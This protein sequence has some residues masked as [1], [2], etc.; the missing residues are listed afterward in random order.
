MH[1]ASLCSFIAVSWLC[2]HHRLRN[3]LTPNP[4]RQD[5]LHITHFLISHTGLALLIK[6]RLYLAAYLTFAN[7]ATLSFPR[8]PPSL[9]CCLFP[10]KPLFI[11]RCETR[12]SYSLRRRIGS[13]QRRWHMASLFVLA[14][15]IP[16]AINLRCSYLCDDLDSFIVISSLLHKLCNNSQGDWT[17]LSSFLSISPNLYLPLCLSLFSNIYEISQLHLPSRLYS[18]QNWALNVCHSDLSCTVHI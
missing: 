2:A 17:R 6:A 18:D 11:K 15:N 13:T 10:W 12:C 7:L 9:T 3:N 16:P 5:K 8:L 1:K 4:A 14:L